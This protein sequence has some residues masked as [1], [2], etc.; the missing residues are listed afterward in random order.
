MDE[1]GDL[2]WKFNAPYRNGGSSRYLT[3]ASLV[4]SPNKKHLPKRLIKKLY[5]KFKW[6][7]NIEKKWADMSLPERVWFSRKANELQTK[8]SDDIQYL[9][10][11]V[12]KENVQDHI[13]NDANKL[14][15]YMIGLSLLNEMSKHGNV[16]FIPDPRSIKVESG[17]SLHDYLQT[18]LWFDLN[19]KTILETTPIDSATSRNVQFSDMLS[20]VIQGHFEDGN[21]QPWAELRTR[22]S[23]K[24]LF[25]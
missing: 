4:T 24:T 9:S 23:Y 5:T 7:T 11:T 12:K 13:K 21:S 14:Y 8:H 17:N 16:T 25:F 18:Q 19:V 1:S 3:I 15:N 22:I 10:I 6:P 2:G 20:G